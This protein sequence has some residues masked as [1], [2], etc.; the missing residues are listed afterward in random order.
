MAG[1]IFFWLDRPTVD[2]PVGVVLLSSF[3]WDFFSLSELSRSVTQSNNFSLFTYRIV[4]AHKAADPIST[5]P[6]V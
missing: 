2:R 6:A 5:A 3:S 4:Q 1:T